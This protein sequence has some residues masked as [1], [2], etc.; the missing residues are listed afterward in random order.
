MRIV[1]AG[2][3]LVLAGTSGTSPSSPMTRSS[4]AQAG[5]VRIAVG[6]I[7]VVALNDGTV[8]WP[9]RTV[10]PTATAEQ[11]DRGLRAVGLT[12]PVGMT[13]SGFLVRTKT[14]RILVDVGTGGKFDGMAAFR[15]AGQLLSNLR[16]AGYE[17]DQIDEIY[18]SHLGP[19]HIGALANTTSGATFPNAKLRAARLEV[20]GFMDERLRHGP[21]SLWRRFQ[22]EMFAPYIAAGRFEPFDGDVE[23]APGITAL[24]TPGH[25]PGHTSYLV[26]SGGERLLILGD[27]LH[28]SALQFAYPSLPTLFDAD[29]TVGAQQRERILKLAAE[30]NYLVAGAHLP[31]PGIGRVRVDGTGY[32]WVP[33]SSAQ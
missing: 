16:A 5:H 4:E 30:Q 1:V 7:E 8:P 32:R 15:G 6:D 29:R 9:T 17:P 25:T 27:V 10:L 19:D 21:D 20:A 14:H 12:D 18:I 24:A 28:L 23:L 26:E 31:F 33:I 2:I 22:A 13:Y 3:A 11:I